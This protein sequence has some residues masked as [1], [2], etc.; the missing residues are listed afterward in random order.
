[1]KKIPCLFK[2]EYI[3]QKSNILNEVTLGCEWVMDGNGIA[4]IKYDGTACMIRSGKMYK[5]YDAKQGKTPPDN[6]ISCQPFPDEITKHW[7]GWIEV[8]DEPESKWHRD[9]PYTYL[10]DGTY[11]LIGLKI[12]SN[13]YNLTVHHLVPHGLPISKTII[14]TFEGIKCFLKD[15]NHE[16]IV[17]HH[18][19]GRMVKIRRKDFGFD[20]PIK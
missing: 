3:G 17:F 2:K 16:G 18:E 9:V 20:W 12:N 19:D 1:M 5:R 8:G 6:W 4:T 11:E 13:P 15:F 7:P 10:S 14:R